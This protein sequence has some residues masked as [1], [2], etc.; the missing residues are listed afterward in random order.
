MGAKMT[1]TPYSGGNPVEDAV[2]NTEVVLNHSQSA[3]NIVHTR[4]WLSNLEESEDNHRPQDYEHILFPLQQYLSDIPDSLDIRLLAGTDP[5]QQCVIEPAREYVVEAAYSAEIPLE[6]GD[7]T[8]VTY[9]DT[10]PDMPEL[11]GQLLQ[12]GDLVLTGNVTSSLPVEVDMKVNL[13]DSD[14]GRVPL[15]ESTSSQKIKGCGPGGE[16]VTTDIYMGVQ[17]QDGT[18]VKDVSA[19]E[20]EFT[21][22]TVGG[23]P[24]SDRCFIQ[25]SL[26]ALVPKG[27][28]V[29]LEEYM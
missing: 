2:W 11:V 20:V 12:L 27:V 22:S 23:V 18:Q 5:Q 28:S 13:L 8:S 3:D 21:V 26:Q 14:G 9:R 17:K 25:A 16:A 15:D 19:I 29:D 4:Y 7:G 10:I 1:I 6:F 24:L